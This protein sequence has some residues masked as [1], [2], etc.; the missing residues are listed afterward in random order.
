MESTATASVETKLE[1]LAEEI[2]NVHLTDLRTLDDFATR[3]LSDAKE[4]FK[5]ARRKATEAFSNEALTTADRI[6]A[7]QYRVMATQSRSFP[8]KL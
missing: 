6:L 5:D 1:T 7:M 3:A 2:K 4:R 8:R